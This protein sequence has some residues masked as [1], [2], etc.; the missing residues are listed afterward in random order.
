MSPRKLLGVCLGRSHILQCTP[1]SIREELKKCQKNHRE[2]Q[3]TSLS[4][5][6][7]SP[8]GSSGVSDAAEMAAIGLPFSPSRADTQRPASQHRFQQPAEPEAE[9]MT[10]CQDFERK[11]PKNDK[12][13]MPEAW[14]KP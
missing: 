5:S 4:E 8:L 14:A 7:T 13:K 3:R 12:R 6:V 11:H 2:S 9:N 10:T 1:G